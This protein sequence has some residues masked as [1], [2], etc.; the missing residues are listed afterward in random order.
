MHERVGAFNEEASNTAIGESRRGSV[1]IVLEHPWSDIMASEDEEK[2]DRRALGGHMSVFID[3]DGNSIRDENGKIVQLAGLQFTLSADP[4][5]RAV[6][7][8]KALRYTRRACV[9]KLVWTDAK[10]F[11]VGMFSPFRFCI[12]AIN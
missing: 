6:W 8:N 1:F 4:I 5:Y 12:L 10:P 9:D 7:Y 11:I 3:L 2:P